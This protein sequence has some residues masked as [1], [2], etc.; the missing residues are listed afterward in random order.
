MLSELLTSL[1]EVKARLEERL[2]Q[3]PEYPALLIVDKAA[4]QVSEVLALLRPLPA[5]LAAN[6]SGDEPTQAARAVRGDGPNADEPAV[7]ATE[8]ARPAGAEPR[9]APVEA[10][11][12]TRP[13]LVDELGAILSTPNRAPA[14]AP[15]TYLP[16][17]VAGRRPQNS[18]I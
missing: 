2:L 3:E 7:M 10:I 14:P 13:V 11:D 8:S 17:F 16:F 5:A 12:V 6:E 15:R 18:R 1:I 9:F 4:L